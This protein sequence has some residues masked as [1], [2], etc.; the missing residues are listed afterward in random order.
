MGQVQVF[1]FLTFGIFSHLFP[2]AR[3][4]RWGGSL[5][6]SRGRTSE[7]ASGDPTDASSGVRLGIP[8]CFWPLPSPPPAPCPHFFLSR[9]SILTP[10]E[11]ALLAPSTSWSWSLLLTPAD[12]SVSLFGVSSFQ[13]VGNWDHASSWIS[14]WAGQIEILASN[15]SP[16]G[17]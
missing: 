6:L 2:S 5:G 1:H 17:L 11:S 13:I 10:K 16:S 3:L 8:S 15:P 4:W 14:H 9:F 7:A 12:S